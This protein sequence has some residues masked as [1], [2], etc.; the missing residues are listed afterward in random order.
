[1]AAWYGTWE[2][3][4]LQSGVAADSVVETAGRLQRWLAD[5]IQGVGVWGF[6]T[7]L[8]GLLLVPVVLWRRRIHQASGATSKDQMPSEND[9]FTQE[10]QP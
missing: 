3:R 2:L 10:N 5:T 7:I 4:V 1:V 8:L 6:V 9:S